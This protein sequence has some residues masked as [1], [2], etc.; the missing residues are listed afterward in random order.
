[1]VIDSTA[2]PALT[3]VLPSL[4]LSSNGMDGSTLAL[5]SGVLASP[6]CR[7]ERLNL[8]VNVITNASI[9]PFC[10]S[11]RKN[12]SLCTLNLSD[13]FL[14]TQSCLLMIRTMVHSTLKLLHL[15][16]N[17]VRVSVEDLYVWK[18]CLE[19]VPHLVR[20]RYIARKYHAAIKSCFIKDKVGVKLVYGKPYN[21]KIGTIQVR[22]KIGMGVKL[23]DQHPVEHSLTVDSRSYHIHTNHRED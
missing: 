22:L 5:F 1:M 19:K 21:A 6:Q 3:T 2:I 10:M 12:K 14:G 13:N 17:Q 18:V 8:S 4:D 16:S 15:D 7:L 23:R 11:L 9:A 20:S